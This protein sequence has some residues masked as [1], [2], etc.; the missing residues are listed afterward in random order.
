MQFSAKKLGLTGDS[1]G[2]ETAASWPVNISVSGSGSSLS[3]TSGT[4]DAA[5]NFQVT[6][7]WSA[8]EQKTKVM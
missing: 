6:L 2:E 7:T 8:A 3:A 4:T 1:L 5:S